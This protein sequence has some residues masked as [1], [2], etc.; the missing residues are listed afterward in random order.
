MF[1]GCGGGRRRSSLFC[2]GKRYAIFLADSAPP[3]DSSTE[4]E[5]AALASQSLMLP[6]RIFSCCPSTQPLFVTALEPMGGLEAF[7]LRVCV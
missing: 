3:R 6:N 1:G 5:E 2:E 7:M 4:L